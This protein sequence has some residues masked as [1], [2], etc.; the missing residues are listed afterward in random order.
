MQPRRCFGNDLFNA[1][2]GASVPAAPEAP[3]K[4]RKLARAFEERPS[5]SVAET[6]LKVAGGIEAAI[7]R[8]TELLSLILN[9]MERQGGSTSN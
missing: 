9:A 3:R 2:R 6:L 7:D 4:R 8:Q 5:L 1:Q